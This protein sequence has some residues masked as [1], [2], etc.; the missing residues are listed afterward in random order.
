M[1]SGKECRHL[2]SY[3]SFIQREVPKLGLVIE[4][5]RHGFATP[6]K[7]LLNLVPI[8]DLQLLMNLGD[9]SGCYWSESVV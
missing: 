9:L 2:K 5:E 8:S 1:T 4:P 7:N 6:P 3:G